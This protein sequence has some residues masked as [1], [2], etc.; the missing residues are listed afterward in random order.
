MSEPPGASPAS[1]SI[2]ARTAPAQVRGRR[3]C[4]GRPPREG[5][6]RGAVGGVRGRRRGWS[7]PGGARRAPDPARPQASPR[8][9]GGARRARAERAVRGTLSGALILEALT[10]LFVPRAIAPLE[11]RTA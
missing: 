2:R 5:S 8:R 6:D 10:V 7:R 3:R 4:G 11:R 1:G 9:D